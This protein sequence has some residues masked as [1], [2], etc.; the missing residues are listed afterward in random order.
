M[1]LKSIF[2]YPKYPENL[3]RL[4]ELAYNLWSVWDY[5][6]VDL[7]YR[8][9]AR[10]F[11]EINHNPLHLL[12]SLS[13]EKLNALSADKGFLFELDK[14][15][16]KF[17]HYRQYS[18][19]YK[20]E[21]IK[22]SVISADDKIAY[23]SMEFGLHEC[24]P[25]YAGGLGVLAGDFLK[26][27]SDFDLPV[28][29]VGLLYKFG[30]FTQYIDPTGLQ[31]EVYNEFENHLI[32]AKELLDADG[33]WAHVAVRILDQE[34]K[35]KLWRIDVGKSELILLDTDIDDNPVGMRSIT[36]ELYVSDRDK[37]IQQEL[38]IGIGGIKALNLLGIKTKIYHFNE[39]HSV[40]AIIGRLHDLMVKQRFSFSEAKAIIRASTVFTTHTPV[41]AGNEN[42]EVKMVKKYL[43]PW[44]KEIGI[45]FDQFVRMG[46]VDGDTKTFWLPALAMQFSRY[47]NG[48]SNQH[49]RI[50]RVMWTGLFHER[51]SAEIPITA[52][53]NGVHTSWISQSFTELF[54]RYL[55]P[56]FIHCGKREDVWKNIY[57]IPD[58]E[59]WEEHRR[60]KK[61]MINFIR[62]QC[63][64]QMTAGGYSQAG[65]L[66]VSGA[67]NA[68]YLTVVF[69]RRFAGYKRPTLILKDK[70]RFKKIL[71]SSSRPVQIIFAGKAHPADLESKKMIKEVIDFARDHNLEDRVIFIEN[72]DIN[73]ARH[74]Y[75]GADVWLNNPAPDMEASGT[76]GMKAGMNGVLHLSTLEGWW[77][78][79]YNGKNGWAITA[80]T[81]YK[82]PELQ[83]AADANQ[84]YELLEHEIT[85]LYY[86]RNEADLPETW[87]QMMK[88]SIFSICQNFNI[89]RMICDYLREF[90]TLASREST[91][92]SVDDYKLLR[93]AIQEEKSVLKFWDDV[94]IKSFNLDV[95]KKGKLTG[96]QHI[97]VE[98]GVYF[99]QAP[100]ELFKVELFYLYGKNQD[101]KILPLEST[102]VRDGLTY[103]KYP[104]ELAG[105]GPQGL[106]VRIMPANNIVQDI[107]PEL[108]KWKD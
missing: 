72:Y 54:D 104:L 58:H 16:Q 18:G 102:Q 21:C 62:R 86:T 8:I 42:M 22:E 88:D 106:N 105:Y 23:F 44:I 28:I 19:A 92:L 48:V 79:G 84:L 83:D 56:D 3:N 96:G 95:D 99:G 9:D 17:Q 43:E 35:A 24:I 76:S 51:T 15:W 60:N 100:A 90:Y 49:A 78:D 82:N 68:D 71:T 107:H 63:N 37:R 103:Y 94:K 34:V 41:I 40:F 47:I 32:P 70:E 12:L 1:N 66:D 33:N 55:G 50:S 7:F 31:Q 45:D 25:I 53:T 11:R 91:A 101:Y 67:L 74:L 39:G 80:G 6:A 4:Y 14:V 30:Y 57:H 26:G 98:C 77:L 108:I 97:D 27:V 2:V 36:D 93:K 69:A 46:F 5:D 29:G 52:V 59:L 81:L 61:E 65:I 38:I 64:R 87:I 85:E 89:N 13:R 20:E 10:L 75:W 73:V